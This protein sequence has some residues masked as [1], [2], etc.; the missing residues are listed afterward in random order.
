MSENHVYQSDAQAVQRDPRA[1]TRDAPTRQAMPPTSGER[2]R[3]TRR[4]ADPLHFDQR[5]VP[6]G[7]SYEWK[8]DDVLGQPNTTHMI[9]LRENH[10]RVVPASRHP[11]LAYAGASEIRR[12][13]LVLMERPKYLTEEAQMEDLGLALEPVQH[14]EEVMYGTKPGQLT[15]DHPSVRKLP[16]VRQQWSPGEPVNEAEP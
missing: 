4:T 5:I 9:G 14:M 6:V 10:R 16:G 3:R 11:E 2:L 7:F 1:Q 13:G 8:C 12:P 15:R